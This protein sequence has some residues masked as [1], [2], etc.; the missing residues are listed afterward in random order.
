MIHAKLTGS[1][2][3]LLVVMSGT[4]LASAFDDCTQAPSAEIRVRACSQVIDSADFSQAQKAVAYRNRGRARTDA[5]ALDLALPDLDAALR[6]DGDD[7]V[8]FLH[9]ALVRTA[10]KDVD[11]AIS[12]YTNVI[13]LRSNMAGGYIGRG[14]AYLLKQNAPAAI[15]DF[16]QA[17]RVAPTNASAYNNRGLAYKMAGDVERA[18]ADFTE[19]L[20]INPIYALAYNN[21]GYAHEAAGRKTLA[22][23]DFRSA[24]LIDPS[25]IGA[26]DGLARLDAGSGATADAEKLVFEGR[27]LVEQHCAACHAIGSRGESP[28]PRA[29]VFRSL[30]QRHPL[31]GLREPLTRGIAAPH[32]EMPKFRL[33]NADID[34][35]VAY[36]YSL[37]E[38][39]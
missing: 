20:N 34:K 23:A 12:D 17:I 6:L 19:A 11:G 9:R 2:L 32:D 7:A 25:L 30:H 38:K 1:A 13:R 33:P 8:A 10:K 14:H 16:T 28:N 37:A 4:A 27:A 3:L 31:Q 24:L 18:I 29:P 5:G 15:A 35:V 39:P 22:I 36:I 26:K 21:R